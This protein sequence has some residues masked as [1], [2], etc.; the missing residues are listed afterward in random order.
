MTEAFRAD[1][2]WVTG[3]EGGISNHPSDPGGFT[4]K[5]IAR[6]KHPDETE[7]WDR[8][9]SIGASSILDDAIVNEHIEN[10]YFKDYY[11]PLNCDRMP[12]RLRRKVFDTAVNVGRRR[13]ARWVQRT[14]NLADRGSDREPLLV[15]GGI[16]DKTIEALLRYA[17]E[18]RFLTKQVAGFQMT[19]YQSLCEKRKRFEA[20]LRGWTNRAFDG[21]LGSM[22]AMDHALADLVTEEDTDASLI[23]LDP[24]GLPL[25]PAWG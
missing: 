11:G 15:D 3:H 14:V 25:V 20:F 21:V 13:C 17:A 6:K 18:D 10:I 1:L 8:V 4:V 16:G 22:N 24:V 5:G 2:Q 9:L 7:L 23:T 12:F 19:H